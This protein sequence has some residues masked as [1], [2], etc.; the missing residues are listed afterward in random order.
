MRKNF[1]N[2]LQLAARGSR[3]FELV[4]MLL[5]LVNTK[6]LPVNMGSDKHLMHERLANAALRSD[7]D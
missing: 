3:L 5:G 4:M 1:K 7:M 2:A 6:L